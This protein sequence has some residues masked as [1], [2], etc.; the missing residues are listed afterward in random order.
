MFKELFTEIQRD[1]REKRNPILVAY[2]KR[3]D[4]AYIDE[5]G[6]LQIKKAEVG[7]AREHASFSIDSLADYIKTHSALDELQC[8]W[9]NRTSITFLD[10][11]EFREDVVK[12]GL[13]DS[14]QFGVIKKWPGATGVTG[15]AYQQA[16]LIR[17]LRVDLRGCFDGA[18]KLIDQIRRVNWE[19]STTGEVQRGSEKVSIGSKLTTQLAG[20]NELPEY[21]IFNVPMFKEHVFSVQPIECALE[22]DTSG[23][24]FILIPI[25]GQIE[26]AIAASEQHIRLNLSAALGKDSPVQ[27]Y[28]GEP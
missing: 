25:P 10:N 22:I 14:H 1:A 3:K 26:A 4:A 15:G 7:P 21:V 20:T 28:Y 18:A 17:L 5:N 6:I 13:C 2:D 9:Y 11:D 23:R 27:I 24:R 16:D 19:A 12:I 8:V